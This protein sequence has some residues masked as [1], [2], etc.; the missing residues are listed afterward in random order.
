MPDDPKTAPEAGAQARLS[1][2]FRR[3]AA[4][5][6]AIRLRFIDD[7]ELARLAPGS[8]VSLDKIARLYGCSKDALLPAM[9]ELKGRGLLMQ[10]GFEWRV[11]PIEREAL[12]PSLGARLTLEQ[13]VAEAAA[14]N[15]SALNRQELAELVG[16]L[17]RSA[18]IGDID[19][20]MLSDKRLEKALAEASGL[21]ETAELLF[22]AKREFR[23]AWCA[24]NRLGDLSVPANLREALVNA[25]LA[26]KPDEARDA[27]SRFI[28]YLRQS[29]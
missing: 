10:D 24:H 3:A 25:L 19:G 5:A 29:F 8:V 22:A 13:E 9:L 17:Q 4:K 1:A 2:S 14:L 16:N 11:A 27:V 28:D 18:L 12:I 21:P 6:E 15:A 20:Y 7:V 26:G 23:R